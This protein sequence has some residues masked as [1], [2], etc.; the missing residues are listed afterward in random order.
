MS[1]KQGCAEP[2]PIECKPMS[3]TDGMYANGYSESVFSLNR[4]LEF[5]TNKELISMSRFGQS[6]PAQISQLENA[7][8]SDLMAVS[9]YYSE[10]EQR[11]AKL[12]CMKRLGLAAAVVIGDRNDWMEIVSPMTLR[13]DPRLCIKRTGLGRIMASIMDG[14]PLVEP[15]KKSSI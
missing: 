4:W 13:K 11:K 14:S 15:I 10:T 2:H 5:R 1:P 9:G 8:L 6:A 7:M 3:V 12:R